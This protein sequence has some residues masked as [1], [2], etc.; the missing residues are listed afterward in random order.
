MNSD[1]N[2]IRAALADTAAPI[3]A[4]FSAEV[5]FR[6]GRRRRI[7]RH[8]RKLPLLAGLTAA[9]IL[10]GPRVAATVDALGA[11]IDLPVLASGLLLLL[12]CAA[13]APRRI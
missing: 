3:D 12:F 1:E 10:L 9:L 13:L 11:R 2:A 6:L 5:L 8:A 7:L 4:R